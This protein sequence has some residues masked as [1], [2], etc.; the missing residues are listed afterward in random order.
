ML[1]GDRDYIKH[2]LSEGVIIR[3]KISVILFTIFVLIKPQAKHPF[4]KENLLGC[5]KAPGL[6]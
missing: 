3:A 4:L 6:V 5:A 1:T 2:Y